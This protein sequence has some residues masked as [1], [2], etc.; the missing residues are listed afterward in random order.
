MQW[1]VGR[2]NVTW[3]WIVLILRRP[4]VRRSVFRKQVVLVTRTHIVGLQ[5]KPRWLQWASWNLNLDV[6]ILYLCL[7]SRA[8]SFRLVKVLFVYRVEVLSSLVHLGLVLDGNGVD[9]SRRN[10]ACP[11]CWAHSAFN[12]LDKFASSRINFYEWVVAFDSLLRRSV[13]QVDLARLLAFVYTGHPNWISRL[14]RLWFRSHH[15]FLE[16]VHSWVHLRLFLDYWSYKFARRFLGDMLSPVLWQSSV[17][18]T[19]KKVKVSSFVFNFVLN[20]SSV[21]RSAI[22]SRQ[23]HL[24]RNSGWRLALLSLN[25]VFR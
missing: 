16:A 1:T 7:Y 8:S 6:W 9:I 12:A 25:A 23:K 13:Q 3:V 22:W 14:Q 10:P 4:V 19:V 20:G 17:L 2:R 5:G 11:T 18:G 21:G 24:S 15:S